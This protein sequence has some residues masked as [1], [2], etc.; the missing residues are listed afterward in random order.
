MTF[1]ISKTDSKEVAKSSN[2]RKRESESGKAFDQIKDKPLQFGQ[3]QESHITFQLDSDRLFIDIT[4][5]EHKWKIN[6]M[7]AFSSIGFDLDYRTNTNIESTTLKVEALSES[8]VYRFEL[9]STWVPSPP[10]PPSTTNFSIRAVKNPVSG[11]PTKGQAQNYLFNDMRSQ[12]RDEVEDFLDD[13]VTDWEDPKALSWSQLY[14]IVNRKQDED[15]EEGDKE[16]GDPTAETETRFQSHVEEGEDV[17]VLREIARQLKVPVSPKVP[18]EPT[19]K[20]LVV[21]LTPFVS[22]REFQLR[23]ANAETTEQHNERVDEL[24]YQLGQLHITRIVVAER[25]LSMELS[26][27]GPCVLILSSFLASLTILTL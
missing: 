4:F 15:E 26:L 11:R 19:L 25:V 20:E 27:H 24:T 17:I 21:A 16:G 22:H 7:D 5:Q 2:K 12:G 18:N 23:M 8:G 14:E 3:K 13:N 6:S 9:P 1:P 10:V